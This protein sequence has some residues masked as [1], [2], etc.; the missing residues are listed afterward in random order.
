[1]S[2]ETQGAAEVYTFAKPFTFEGQEV[3]EITL[4]F[5]DMSGNDIIACD[6]KYRAEQKGAMSFSPELDKVYQ[7]YVVA[8]AAGVH[9]SLVLASKAK[10][11]TALTLRARNFLLL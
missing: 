7:A 3:K 2:E 6:R 9:V 1:M 4:N 11:F 10:D 8:K 5:D